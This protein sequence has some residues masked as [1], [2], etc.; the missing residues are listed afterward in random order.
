MVS[1]DEFYDMSI[2]SGEKLA[3]EIRYN[4]L[5]LME[6]WQMVNSINKNDISGYEKCLRALERLIMP[7]IKDD[8]KE[9]I[10]ALREK[11]YSEYKSIRPDRRGY[12]EPILINRLLDE[13][14]DVIM[15]HVNKIGLFPKKQIWD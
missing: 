14:A 2:G 9:E 11:F 3:T 15:R 8:Y 12:H 13:R 10:K 1:D 5:V 6:L 7:F 4:D